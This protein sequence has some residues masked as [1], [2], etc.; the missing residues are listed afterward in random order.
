VQRLQAQLGQQAKGRIGRAGSVKSYESE[1]LLAYKRQPV[2]EERFSQ[3][4]TDFHVAPVY[5][6]SV[7]RG[8]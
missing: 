4:G 3:L 5:L 7:S 8:E 2:T 6:K 1:V